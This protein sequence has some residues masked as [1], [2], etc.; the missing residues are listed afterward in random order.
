[1]TNYLRAEDFILIW[2]RDVANGNIDRMLLPDED[3]IIMQETNA[4]GSISVYLKL[5]EKAL[6]NIKTDDK[7][8]IR[9]IKFGRDGR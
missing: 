6:S 1:M 8:I 9:G 7:I 5:T 2:W 4:I 3:Y